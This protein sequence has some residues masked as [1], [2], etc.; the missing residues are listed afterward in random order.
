MGVALKIRT[1]LLW[2]QH[3]LR[4][5]DNTPNALGSLGQK[6]SLGHSAACPGQGHNSGL[7]WEGG[8]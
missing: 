8:A 3:G 6:C 4:I 1:F 7:R 5:V 2:L